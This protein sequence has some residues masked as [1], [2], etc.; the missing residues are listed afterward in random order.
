MAGDGVDLLE[1]S[2][3]G[4]KRID[5]GAVIDVPISCGGVD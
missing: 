5:S 3:G 4:N 1:L 2:D